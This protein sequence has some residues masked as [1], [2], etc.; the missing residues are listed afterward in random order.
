[1]NGKLYMR[2][3]IVLAVL[4][5][6]VCAA[7]SAQAAPKPQAVFDCSAVTEIP[8]AECEALVAL[9]NSTNGPGWRSKEN[10]LVTNTS[11]GWSGVTCAAGHVTE[12]VLS[13]NQLRG[14]IPSELDHLGELTR[15]YLCFNQLSGSIPPEL[16]HLG[17]LQLL[18]LCYNE[19]SGGIPPGL[20]TL[21]DLTYLDLE[22][23]LLGGSI[24]PELGKLGK[25]QNLNLSSNRLDGSIPAD[26]GQMGEL[27]EL[28]LAGNRLSGAIPPE[29]A[30]L[31]KLQALKLSSNQLSGSIPPELGQLS[32]LWLLGLSN[33][34]LSGSIPP[35]L[36]QLTNLRNL[37]LASNQLSGSIPPELG[38]LNKLVELDLSYNHL[39][40]TTPP[41]LSNISSLRILKL[42]G[43]Q[44]SGELPA[45]VSHAPAHRGEPPAPFGYSL[46][47]SLPLI[48]LLAIGVLSYTWVG[49]HQA[50]N[51][52][53]QELLYAMLILSLAAAAQYRLQAPGPTLFFLGILILGVLI[54]HALVHGKALHRLS[55]VTRPI[56]T[57]FVISDALL[58]F[59]FMFQRDFDLPA[60]YE[61][62]G[63]TSIFPST[64]GLPWVETLED[65]SLLLMIAV[66]VSWV[67]IWV[68]IWSAV[69]TGGAGSRSAPHDSTP[70][71]PAAGKPGG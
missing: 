69:S 1:M 18:Y 49:R 66:V 13:G 24:P 39:T 21:T 8:Q 2:V 23:N 14:S 4:A 67:V 50:M 61:H 15:L 45:Q 58:V 52:V 56:L 6:V 68:V 12:L 44:V 53:T 55:R 27:R 9:Y 42:S 3:A 70:L 60:G 41:Q 36:G 32:A 47:L 17:E 25:L 51:G 54:G 63:L 64:G 22:N 5:L 38:Q 7:V 62:S 29:L 26:F 43:N 16:S 28:W 19:L 33:N 59:G 34:Q 40:G 71:P 11:C 10:W 37:L 35:E 31:R 46:V 48:L 30:R 65:A 20:G 57:L